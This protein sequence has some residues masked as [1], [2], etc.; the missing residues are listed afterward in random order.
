MTITRSMT[1]PPT[2]MAGADPEG[3]G[4]VEF[5]RVTRVLSN[6]R[7]WR[8]ILVAAVAATIYAAAFLLAMVLLAI[9]GIVF[10]GVERVM[11]TFLRE[12]DVMDLSDPF[13]FAFAMGMLILLLPAL[14]LATRMVGAG[15]VGLLSSVVGRIR[16]RW[17]ALCGLAAITIYAVAYVTQFLVAVAQGQSLAPTLDMP[18]AAV[19]VVLTLA[20]VPLQAA[21]EEYVF[22]GYLMQTI[23]GWLRHPAFAILL[24][25]PLFVLGHDY[26]LLGMTDVAAFAIAA[27]WLTWR[28]G[29]LEAAVAL[30]VVGNVSGFALAAVGLMDINAT[31]FG[32][33]SLVI[34]L[35]LTLSFTVVVVRLSTGCCIQRTAPLTTDPAGITPA[36]AA[37]TSRRKEL[38]ARRLEGRVRTGRDAQG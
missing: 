5:H 23:G 16:L 7:W 10:P 31:E 32:A 11:D 20:L 22:R 33:G 17:L 18:R 36:T 27:G 26:G 29:G 37:R 6:H 34:S 14:L 9:A 3:L 13:M 15:P 2:T 24:P 28:T 30:H 8:P 38:L 35:L 21:A 1:K 12:A 25:V 19:A 4:G